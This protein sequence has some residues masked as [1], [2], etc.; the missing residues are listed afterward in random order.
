MRA[1]RAFVLGAAATGVLAY[2]AAAVAA[3]L[4]Q[5]QD[6]LLDVHVGA[7]VV[8]RVAS[9]GASTVTTF[10][11]GLLVASAI[12]GL[13]NALGAAWL[14]RRARRRPPMA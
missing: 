5:A 14:A 8:V 2:A 3:G 4:A 7:L 11:P 13:L 12:G 6:G 1:L 9:D 10:G